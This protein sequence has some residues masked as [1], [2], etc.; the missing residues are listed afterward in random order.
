M[1]PGGIV[2]ALPRLAIH[3]SKATVDASV[4]PAAH[5]AHR[6]TVQRCQS[7]LGDGLR[8]AWNDRWLLVRGSNTEPIVRLIAEASSE[9]EAKR[10]CDEAA[11]C[12]PVTRSA[13]ERRLYPYQQAICLFVRHAAFAG[14]LHVLDVLVERAA[15]RLVA[16]GASRPC[17]GRRVRR[18]RRVDVDACSS[19]RRCVIVSPFLT[20]AIGPPS[21]RFGRDVAD[22][23]AVAAAA[24]AAVGDQ[25]DVVRQ[26]RRP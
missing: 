9:A 25:R 1:V 21:L 7:R 3:K 4:L 19:R 22:D 26:G 6:R 14:A 8:L 15:G 17:G 12:P 18:R 2:D 10:M 20:R 23:E 11:T 16:A 24:E 5:A 13:A